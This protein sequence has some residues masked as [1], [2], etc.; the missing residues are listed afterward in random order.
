V[1]LELGGK[2]PLV[3]CD[4]ADLEAAAQAA[5]LSAY[6]NAGQRCAAGSRIIVFDAVFDRF[7]AL[8]LERTEAQRVGPGD[9]DDLGPVINERQL[10]RMLRHVREAKE[11]GA[12][13]LA[14]GHRVDRPGFFMAPTL[15]ENTRELDAS[16][17]FGPITTLHRVSGFEEA[18]E[19]AGAT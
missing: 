14:G 6:S 18:M 11:K 2:N 7:K 8:L 17:L 10:E 19:L 4:D 13:V 15:I 3:V 16:E 9:E 1:C 12:T 5:A